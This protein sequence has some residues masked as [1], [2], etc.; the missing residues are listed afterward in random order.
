MFTY[1]D[2]NS[3]KKGLILLES[4]NCSGE[5]TKLSQCPSPGWNEHNCN[6]NSDIRINCSGSYLP[7]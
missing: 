4:V 7:I 3:D 5:E 1:V 6:H 2:V